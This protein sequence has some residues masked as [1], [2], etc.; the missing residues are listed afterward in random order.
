MA[1]ANDSTVKARGDGTKVDTSK[2]ATKVGKWS[3]TDE[4]ILSE[5]VG[6]SKTPI[7]S[8]EGNATKWDKNHSQGF[9]LAGVKVVNAAV[10]ADH[11]EGKTTTVT[12][13][14]NTDQVQD[15]QLDASKV[16]TLFLFYERNY[17]DAVFHTNGTDNGDGTTS[18]TTAQFIN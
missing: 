7:V 16:N 9:H 12:S 2:Y 15:L 6:S 13:P 5:A 10:S 11:E 3:L 1:F 4:E 18:S 8:K 14:N 17:Y